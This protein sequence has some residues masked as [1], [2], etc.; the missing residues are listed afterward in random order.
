[1]TAATEAKLAREAEI[2]YATIAM[3]TDYDCWHEEHGAVDV[4]AVIKVV[5]DN[6]ERA[7][8]LIGRVLR[9]FPAEHEPCPVGSD[10]ALDTA[11]MTSPGV[12]DP[13]LLAKLDAVAG[14]VLKG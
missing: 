11:I 13:A 6:A 3:V 10:R 8:T 14:R 2:S 5:H 9:E 7:A 4:A 12:R 1:M